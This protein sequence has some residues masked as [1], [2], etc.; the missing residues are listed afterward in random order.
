MTRTPRLRRASTPVLAP[1]FAAAL[2]AGVLA[3]PG[4]GPASAQSPAAGS[5]PDLARAARQTLPEAI[6]ARPQV[7]QMITVSARDWSSRYATL[8]AWSRPAGGEWRLAHA[9]ARV[10]IGYN[11]WV[12]GEVREQSTGTTP[13]GRYTLPYAFGR[14]AD[15]GAR[16]DYR[17][18]D[19][20]DWWPY[21]PRDAATYNVYQRHKAPQTRWRADKA[22]RL[23][24]YTRQYG[25]AMVI[26]FNL[27]K[28]VHY[29]KQR[30]Q[31]VA[32]ERADTRRGGGI[33]LHVKGDGY[34][35]GCVAM[36]RAMMR[37]LVTWVRPSAH[38][39]IVM[40]PHDYIVDL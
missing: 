4:A 30:H 7:R 12:R 1:V 6:G 18:V 13:A 15:P 32:S 31:W 9:P 22:E 8:K 14:W 16:L 26:G 23:D 35:A 34:T 24:S 28:G 20:N 27:P 37:W 19:G 38:A 10:V 29:S 5:A 3:G 11:A 2:A 25:Y 39:R 17:R 33:F 40:G 21:E 36:S